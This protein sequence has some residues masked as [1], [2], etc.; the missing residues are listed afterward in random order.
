MSPSAVIAKYEHAYRQHPVRVQGPWGGCG[1]PA[2]KHVVHVIQDIAPKSGG[3]TAV[4]VDLAAQQV[5]DGHRVT[6]VSA[7]PASDRETKVMLEAR[8]AQLETRPDIRD[9]PS[10]QGAAAFCTATL[11][12]LLP[13]IVHLHG[14]FG[15]SLRS[16]ARWARSRQT[17]VV[18]STHGMLH[19]AAL[20]IKRLKK[21]TY[22]R[23]FGDA[24]RMADVLMTLNEEEANH[25]R[26]RFNPSAVVME[27][28]VN[29]EAF[30]GHAPDMFLQSHPMLAF[31]RY[32]LFVGRLHPIKG[33]DQLIRSYH[34]ARSHGFDH[35][36]VC[37]GPEEG[38]TATLRTLIS[39]L[40]LQDHVFLLPPMYGPAKQSALAGCSMFVHRPRYEG[41][42]IA[43]VEA[44]AA[45]RPVVTTRLCRLDRAIRD[46][47]I[48]PADDTDKA[49]A[50][51]MLAVARDPTAAEAHARQTMQWV[52]DKLSWRVVASQ[53]MDI[54]QG[55]ST[56]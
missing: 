11:A 10:R 39:E 30:F 31:R 33:L 44:M 13:D 55:A 24:V 4:V 8:W 7:S 56:T 14:I 18:C 16:A 38:A 34:L 28:G 21:L 1:Q 17:R 52:R 6:I 35:T 29:P 36:L 49:F 5:K 41:F 27:N 43:V 23:L 46:G 9:A 42:G 3:P 2:R 15:W 20:A 53:T 54:Y 32:A 25:A 37:I 45:G 22:L 51:S 50:E 48:L 40:G 26:A 19:P 47:A 12:S